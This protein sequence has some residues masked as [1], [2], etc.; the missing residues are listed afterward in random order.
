MTRFFNTVVVVFLLGTLSFFF[1]QG[2]A[3]ANFLSGWYSDFNG[4]EAARAKSM[5]SGKPMIVYFYTDW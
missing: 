1:V 5:K 2:S 3:S 4:Y